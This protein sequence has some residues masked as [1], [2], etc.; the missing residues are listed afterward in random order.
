MPL[1]KG[2]RL[3]RFLLTVVIDLPL[4]KVGGSGT[5]L[6]KMGSASHE[7]ELSERIEDESSNVDAESEGGR[8]K[9]L[10]ESEGG[11]GGGGLLIGKSFLITIPSPRVGERA[12]EKS[13]LDDCLVKLV[14]LKASFVGCSTD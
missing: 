1:L 3:I 9:L 12:F 8:E 11:S 13:G 14:L 5:G 2:A 6:G 10:I 4:T 7:P